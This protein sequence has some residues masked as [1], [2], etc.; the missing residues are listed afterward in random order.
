SMFGWFHEGE[1]IRNF[2]L[3]AGNA[4]RELL[5]P[6]RRDSSQRHGR[7]RLRARSRNSCGPPYL[8]WAGNV[9]RGQSLGTAVLLHTRRVAMV[10]PDVAVGVDSTGADA[11]GRMC[12]LLRVFFAPLE[13]RRC[14]HG[15]SGGVGLDL[16]DRHFGTR[17]ESELSDPV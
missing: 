5:L 1:P 2:G 13:S 4:G 6:L 9:G 12:A 17:D 7:S 8:V 3:F 15:I 10:R 14:C 16:S 11:C